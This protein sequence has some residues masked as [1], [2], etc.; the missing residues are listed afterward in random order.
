MES[1][2]TRDESKVRRVHAC[3][4][5][6]SG[7]LS[8]WQRENRR[9]CSRCSMAWLSSRVGQGV[10]VVGGLSPRHHGQARHV[11]LRVVH[12]RPAMVA[13]WYGTGASSEGGGLV[14]CECGY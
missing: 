6:R 5:R 11:L 8:A 3:R 12:G 13:R 2:G 10:A 14:Q 4:L 7:V 1:V 9:G